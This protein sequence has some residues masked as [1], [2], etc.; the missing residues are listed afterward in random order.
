MTSDI[1]RKKIG[2]KKYS[3]TEIETQTIEKILPIIT[4]V[5][6]KII[7]T[8]NYITENEDVILIKDVEFSEIILDSTKTSHIVIKTL[9][10]AKIKPLTGKI[11][12]QYDEIDISRGA[13][14]ELITINGLWYIISS[15]GIK[16]D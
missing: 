13:C 9:T 8:P 11:D 1:I 10:N 5:D 2:Q 7:S 16:L 6:N 12:E 3:F 15:D 4:N 14:V